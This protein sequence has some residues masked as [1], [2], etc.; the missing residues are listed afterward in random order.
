MKNF[1]TNISQSQVAFK[2][3]CVLAI[4][5][6]DGLHKG[7]MRVFDACL[8]LAKKT[9]SIPAILTF[10]PHPSSV[11]AMPHPP[12]KMMF[13][14]EERAQMF[15]AA[16]AKKVFV[17]NFD[18]KFAALEPEEFASYLKKKF[19]K[20][21]GIVTGE[22]FL[23]GNKAHGDHKTLA[24]ICTT[25]K[26]AYIPV[27]R[28]KMGGERISSTRL[29]AALSAGKLGDYKKLAGTEYHA[30]GK[31]VQGR[32]LGRK[33]GFATL[34]LPWNPACKPPFGAY[35]A[36]V[37]DSRGKE[38]N[39]VASYGTNPSVAQTSPTIE[40][41]VLGKTSLRANSTVKIKLIKFLRPQKKF[42]SLEKLANQIQKD[43]I[44]AEKFFDKKV[45]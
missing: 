31:I 45:K 35:V 23:F 28:I 15:K 36:A 13:N 32:K 11:I 25:N 29:R 14:L 8:K 43:K 7:H 19:P 6:F 26:W 18:K 24:E 40:A 22:N 1:P 5:M 3:E 16:G 38:A 4:G 21:K 12:A 17:Q 44:A 42:N 27:R 39:A 34:N 30:K 9:S 10:D 37:I 20:L 41:H 33:L 2:S